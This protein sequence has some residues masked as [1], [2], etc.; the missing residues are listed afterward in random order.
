[1]KI[2]KG[3]SHPCIKGFT[4]LEILVAIV[5]IAILAIGIFSLQGMSWS[6]THQSSQILKAGQLIEKHIEALRTEIAEDKEGNWPPADSSITEGNITLDRII[7]TPDITNNSNTRKMTMIATWGSGTGDS[8]SIVT[9][10]SK[11]F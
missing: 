1:M 8:L 10:V 9:Y 3:H 6:K 7:E 2:P 11:D 5:L 4:L